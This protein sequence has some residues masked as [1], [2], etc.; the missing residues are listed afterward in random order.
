MPSGGCWCN[1]GPH[2]SWRE[3]GKGEGEGEGRGRGEEEREEEEEGRRE[4]GKGKGRE[5]MGRGEVK[6]GGEEGGKKSSLIPPLR[7]KRSD[8]SVEGMLFSYILSGGSLHVYSLLQG[9]IILPR[10]QHIPAALRA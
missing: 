4:E 2:D 3:E 5:G 10:S 7:F 9:I 8:W 1:V 6:E